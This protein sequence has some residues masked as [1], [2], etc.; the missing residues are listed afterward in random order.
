VEEE[1]GT[2][3]AF[4]GDARAEATRDGASATS[5]VDGQELASLLKLYELGVRTVV[6]EQVMVDG[7]WFGSI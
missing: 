6:V 7:E 5:L 3:G 1:L 2:I 4:S